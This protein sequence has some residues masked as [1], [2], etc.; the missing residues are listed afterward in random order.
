MTATL[1]GRSGIVTGASQG[2]G[3]AIAERLAAAGVR[4]VLVAAHVDAE[5]LAEVADRLDAAH[6]ASDVGDPATADVAVELALERHGGLD[7]LASNAGIAYFE[8]VLGAPVEHLDR[9]LH[10]NVR[11]MYLMAVGAARAMAARGGG[12]IC[13][14]ASTA[15]WM[16][17][18]RQVT[19]NASKGAVA[20]LA[21]SLAVDLAPH[22]VRV[23]A[24]APGWVRTPATAEILADRAEWSMHR[25]RVPLD[26]PAEPAEVAEVVAFLLSDAASY[27][28]G[29]VVPCDGGL[30]AGFRGSDWAAVE[31]DPAPR[32]VRAV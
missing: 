23:N 30:T 31:R 9:T 11:G 7:V 4:L 24:V 18:E 29:A 19:Y 21:R 32:A 16:G 13:C 14:T 17:E 15:S 22:A 3:L 28:T 26:R 12:A 8:D 20:E 10:V 1:D 5:E 27:V 2:I 25:T 6:L